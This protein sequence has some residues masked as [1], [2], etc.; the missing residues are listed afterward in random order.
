MR[1]RRENRLLSP[2]GN[3]LNQPSALILVPKKLNWLAKRCKIHSLK[4]Q[5]PA[6]LFLV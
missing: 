5:P 6:E 4:H 3:T 2:T 1:K